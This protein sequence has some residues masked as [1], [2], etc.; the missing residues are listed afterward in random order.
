MGNN[1]CRVF[2]GDGVKNEWKCPLRS[3]RWY[4][5]CG[6]RCIYSLMAL[7]GYL[8]VEEEFE[9]CGNVSGAERS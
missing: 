1:S 3:C 5:C 8:V 4:E 2:I 6:E 7:M 9:V